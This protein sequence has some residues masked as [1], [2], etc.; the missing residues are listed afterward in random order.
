M[1]IAYV[2]NSM[3]GGGA[4][5]PVPAVAGFLR[6]QG[7]EVEIFALMRRNG[8]A[9]A[10]IESAGFKVHV[11]DGAE[12]DHLRA[13]RWLARSMADWRPDLIWT[14]LTRAT[15]LGQIVGDRQDVPVAS[16]Q[17]NAFLKPAN[18][19]L[20][21]ARRRLST[22]WI[23]DS[24]NVAE[25]TRER[26]GLAPERVISWP[27]FAADPDAPQS[28]PWREGETIRVGTLGRLHPAKGYDILIAALAR[29]QA[30]ADLP[31]FEVLIA[32]EGGRKADLETA[33]ATA[34]LTNVRLAGFTD[35]PRAF[36]SQ[37]HL[38]LQP[39]RR[40]GLCIAAHEAMQAGLPC[41][42]SA[43]G[44]MPFSV[45]D[46]VTGA[47]VPPAD[48]EA[49]AQALVRLLSQ[50]QDLAGMG[51]RGRA[52]VFDRFGPDAFARRGAEVLARIRQNIALDQAPHRGSER[53]G[54]ARS[55]VR[56]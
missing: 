44:E 45:A 35:Q 29:V 22:L 38:Y 20:L 18:R 17:H 13:Y 27:L 49:L 34:G 23:A 11:R 6:A 41:I 5:L 46:G 8:R 40:E 2:I 55:E 54:R 3:E 53:V 15:L 33:I 21:R 47:V 9:I 52:R 56:P 24:E 43:V 42:V 36:L 50:P 1:R 48:P 25:L 19:M 7:C 39:S 16:W 37:L 12:S 28:A 31:S 10:P 14:S 26:L 51:S 32:G 30:L 4:A